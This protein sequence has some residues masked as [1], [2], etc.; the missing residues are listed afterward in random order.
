MDRQLTD[1]EAYIILQ[2]GEY[3]IL[4]M[5]DMKG[6]PY[7]VPISYVLINDVIYMHCSNLGGEKLDILSMEKKVCFTVVSNTRV[8]PGE[9][10]TIYWSVNVF[11]SVGI[12]KDTKVK[13]EIMGCMVKKYS[14]TYMEKGQKYIE[15]AI[16]KIHVLKL[17]IGSINGKARKN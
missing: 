4:S 5:V 16:D 14:V 11:G 10:S 1:E 6:N 13:K 2:D 12:E 8:L 9:F 17:D 7:A 15:G 3:G